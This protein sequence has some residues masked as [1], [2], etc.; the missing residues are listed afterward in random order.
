MKK[1]TLILLILIYTVG[2]SPEAFAFWIWSPKTKKLVNPKHVAKDTPEE[3]FKWAM[4]LYNAEEYKRAAEEFSRLATAFKDS[5][6]APEAQYYAGKSY[7]EG[8]KP[9]PAFL[10]YQKVIDIYP[11]TKRIDEIIEWEYDIGQVFYA[12]NTGKLMGVELMPDFERSIE[13]FSKVRDNAPFGDYAPKAQF[14]IGLSHKK[15]EQYTEAIKAFQKLADE[16]QRSNFYDKATY[17]VAQ[18]TYLASLKSDY[19]QELTDEA[20]KEFKT[21]VESRKGLDIS[22]DAEEAVSILEERKAK[23]LFKTAKFYERQKQYRS[24]VVY[25][26]EI[27][28]KY[29][30][31]SFSGESLRNIVKLENL[32]NLIEEKKRKSSKKKW[33]FF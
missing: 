5:D 22:K 33:I 20:I 32:I 16:Y 21:I 4:K 23:S 25:Y 30:K 3:Q 14:M 27:L 15:V 28:E 7:E 13:I 26:E 24:A 18:C 17:E 6:L 10:A 11:F 8:G 1:Y 9:Y 29:P 2:L 12:K 31:S 19:D